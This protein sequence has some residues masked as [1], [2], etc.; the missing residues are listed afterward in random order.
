MVLT[1]E[2]LYNITV[3]LSDLVNPWTFVYN[4]RAVGNLNVKRSKVFS[5]A[6]SIHPIRGHRP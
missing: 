4:K 6:V 3:F 5:T 2:Y 1:G